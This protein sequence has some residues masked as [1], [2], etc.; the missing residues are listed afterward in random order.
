MQVV[1]NTLVL[2]K[3]PGLE[4]CLKHDFLA[5]CILPGVCSIPEAFCGEGL[6]CQTHPPS[7]PCGSKWTESHWK[8]MRRKLEG[9]DLSL[10]PEQVTWATQLYS[11]P[12]GILLSV[13]PSECKIIQF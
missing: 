12:W 8:E 13:L 5:P 4:I 6:G 7:D 10:P 3:S 2:A 9:L 1:G 11:L